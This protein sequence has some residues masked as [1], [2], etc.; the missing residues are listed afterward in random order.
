MVCAQLLDEEPIDMQTG[1]SQR[2]L[3]NIVCAYFGEM[4]CGAMTFLCLPTVLRVCSHAMQC[5]EQCLLLYHNS[6]PPD[7]IV[8][9]NLTDI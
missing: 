5:F 6:I 7:F 3:N 9:H 8:V 1:R 4:P 2:T